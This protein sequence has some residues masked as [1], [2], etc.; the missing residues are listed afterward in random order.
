MNAN[1]ATS[2][3][4]YLHD[5]QADA[6]DGFNTVVKGGISRDAEELAGGKWME[7]A[8]EIKRQLWV[9]RNFACVL[10]ARSFQRNS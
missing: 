2:S 6:F 1:P 7:C 9:T 4:T 8:V 3:T 5:N 10:S